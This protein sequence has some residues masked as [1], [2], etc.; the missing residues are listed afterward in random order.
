[1]FSAIQSAQENADRVRNRDNRAESPLDGGMDLGTC[2][3]CGR[4]LT[5]GNRGGELSTIR[6]VLELHKETRGCNFEEGIQSRL[7]QSFK[8]KEAQWNLQSHKNR[9]AEDTLLSLTIPRGLA[10]SFEAECSSIADFEAWTSQPDVLR[11][12]ASICKSCVAWREQAKKP[13]KKHGMI[14]H[15]A[16][17]SAI[18]PGC[19]TLFASTL[20]PSRRDSTP[21]T[22]TLCLLSPWSSLSPSLLPSQV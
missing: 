22:L 7:S 15:L 3:S 17:E 16:D 20:T 11:Y 21:F 9:V 6:S 18:D 2:A 4:F 13:A 14:G 12:K 1:M 10:S 5:N 19:G 8:A